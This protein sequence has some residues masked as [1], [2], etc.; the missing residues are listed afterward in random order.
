MRWMQ[1]AKIRAYCQAKSAEEDRL[2]YQWAAGPGKEWPTHLEMRRRV[3]GGPEVPTEVWD[4]GW[5]EAFEKYKEQNWRLSP[6]EVANDR[7]RDQQSAE[8]GKDRR[9]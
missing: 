8:K 1:A 4:E 3:S 7:S 2:Y 5:I 6:I 9:D